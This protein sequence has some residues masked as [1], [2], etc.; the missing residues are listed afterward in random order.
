MVRGHDSAV[1][2]GR[3]PVLRVGGAVADLCRERSVKQKVM[4]YREFAQHLFREG[5]HRLEIGEVE[6]D[7]KGSPRCLAVRAHVRGCRVHVHPLAAAEDH[8]RPVRVEAPC[9]LEAD[10]LGAACD[11]RDLARQAL[12]LRQLEAVPLPQPG[13]VQEGQREEADEVDLV[14]V[15]RRVVLKRVQ[16][17]QPEQDPSEGGHPEYG[18]ARMHLWP[19]LLPGA[20]N[21]K[22]PPHLRAR[23]A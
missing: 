20:Q 8:V 14:V 19:G 12:P 22:G 18:G 21:C 9:G 7:A 3:H 23:V 11:N 6:R 1:P 17:V 16:L 10:A 15:P 5:A 13:P 4:H 2:A